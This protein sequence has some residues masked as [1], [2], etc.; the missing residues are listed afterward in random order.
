MP[1]GL[2]MLF[3]SQCCLGFSTGAIDAGVLGPVWCPPVRKEVDKLAEIQ[4]SARRMMGGL[5]NL[6]CR[7]LSVRMFMRWL[8]SELLPGGKALPIVVALQSHRGRLN[9][10]QWLDVEARQAERANNDIIRLLQTANP[11]YQEGNEPLGDLPG[12]S[13]SL[14]H[15]P[16]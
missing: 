2:G 4:S 1:S 9:M 11:L 10:T 5:G 13:W 6:P 15:W 3:G 14:P 16:F 8:R 12:L 7:K